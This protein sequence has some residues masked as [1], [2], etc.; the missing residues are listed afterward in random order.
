MLSSVLVF[1]CPV[2][3]G[4]ENN[5]KAGQRRHQYLVGPFSLVMGNPFR[6]NQNRDSALK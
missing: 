2:G 5:I 4:S 3:I 1:T 6:E